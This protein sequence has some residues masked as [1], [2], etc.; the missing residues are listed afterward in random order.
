MKDYYQTLGLRRA[1]SADEI[2]K[3]YLK[4]AKKLHPDV[5]AQNNYFEERFKSIQEAYEVLSDP[6]KKLKYD[7]DWAN[8]HQPKSSAP[9]P[10]P[11]FKQPAA[12][13]NWAEMFR[14]Q[15]HRARKKQ[16]NIQEERKRHFYAMLISIGVVALLI[17]VAVILFYL[18]VSI[19]GFRWAWLILL[20][21]IFGGAMYKF[22]RD[23][24]KMKGS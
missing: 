2:R 8:A 4:L 9:K 10:P 21:L 24:R 23:Y 3:A 5:N 18:I 16:E 20:L 11:N 1:A 17:P 15:Q 13:A 6:S 12:N 14:R 19:A 22:M 7:Q